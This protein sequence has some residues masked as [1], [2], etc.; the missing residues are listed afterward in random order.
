MSKLYTTKRVSGNRAGRVES[1]GATKLEDWDRRIYR[2]IWL[3]ESNAE[4]HTIGAVTLLILATA[5]MAVKLAKVDGGDSVPSC[6]PRSE[7]LA[8]FVVALY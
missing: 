5:G 2:N 4:C 1:L 8:T 6:T 3:G 7:A